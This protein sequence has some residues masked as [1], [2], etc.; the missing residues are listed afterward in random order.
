MTIEISKGNSYMNRFLQSFFSFLNPQQPLIQVDE[1]EE[2]EMLS[3]LLSETLN[4]VDIIQE[5]PDF[6]QHLL[7][8]ESLH[9]LFIEC[10]E[11]LEAE[12]E[13]SLLPLPFPPSEDLRF[14]SQMPMPPSVEQLSPQNWRFEWRQTVAQLHNLFGLDAV[15]AVTRDTSVFFEGN[16]HS[17]IRSNAYFMDKSYAVLLEMSPDTEVEGDVQFCVL[18][19]NITPEGGG[20]PACQA[21]LHWGSYRQTVNIP[22]NGRICFPPVALQMVM[23]P[24]KD[25]FVDD[26]QFILEI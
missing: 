24:T 5:H 8:D 7:A 23:N 19:A 11:V 4:G 9:D 6:Y 18:I 2:F 10:L 14:L 22:P 15:V 21:T 13:N 12:K 16:W 17:V 3:F 26:L 20:L 25:D 1:G